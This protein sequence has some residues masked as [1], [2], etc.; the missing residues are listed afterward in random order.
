MIC[1]ILI[2]GS[3][4]FS[5]SYKKVF[6]SKK[7][8]DGSGRIVLIA[9]DNIVVENISAA[10][11]FIGP[12]DAFF[13]NYLDTLTF[14]NKLKTKVSN[15]YYDDFRNFE[16]GSNHLKNIHIIVM[17]NFVDPIDFK[18]LAVIKFNTK[19]MDWV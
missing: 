8:E 5:E 14:E 3:F 12:V 4:L 16:L 1:V 2:F 10:F 7:K 9:A 19:K 18:I 11:R 17:E 6:Y 13:Y 15:I